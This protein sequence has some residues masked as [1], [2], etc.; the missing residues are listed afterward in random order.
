M[1]IL[2]APHKLVQQSSRHGGGDIAARLR[3]WHDEA[4]TLCFVYA[5]SL[6]GLMQSGR[7]RIA[8]LN[9]MAL[10]IDANGST[11]LIM[12]AG[13]TCDDAPQIFFTPNLSSYFQVAGIGISLG[14]H[15]WLF[16]SPDEVPPTAMP[17]RDALR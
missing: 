17:G 5:R 15:D 10:T 13:A 7:G 14:N 11:L 12:L 9:D 2:A 1:G 8:A 4:T 3:A 6:G 16:F